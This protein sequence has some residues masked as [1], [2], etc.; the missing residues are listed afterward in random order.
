MGCVL[1]MQGLP[2]Q[3]P[4]VDL[5]SLLLDDLYKWVI[6]TGYSEDQPTEAGLQH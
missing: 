2:Q 1:D 3:L 4:G 6:V 5:D